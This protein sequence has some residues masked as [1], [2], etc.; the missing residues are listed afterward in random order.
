MGLVLVE[1]HSLPLAVRR[2]A[3]NACQRPTLLGI[4]EVEDI[5]PG[6]SSSGC[7]IS[8]M[9]HFRLHLRYKELHGDDGERDRKNE[10]GREKK[11]KINFIIILIISLGINLNFS[12]LRKIMLFVAMYIYLRCFWHPSTFYKKSNENKS[13]ATS[14]CT[15]NNN[16]PQA[17]R[18]YELVHCTTSHQCTAV[19]WRFRSSRSSNVCNLFRD[20][21]CHTTSRNVHLISDHLGRVEIQL[22]LTEL[23]TAKTQLNYLLFVFQYNTMLAMDSRILQLHLDSCQQTRDHWDN[24]KVLA[25][26]QHTPNIDRNMWHLQRHETLAYMGLLA[27]ASGNDTSLVCVEMSEIINWN[28]DTKVIAIMIKATHTQCLPSECEKGDEGCVMVDVIL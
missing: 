13:V 3:M 23:T 7:M 22:I 9:A 24:R 10:T 15:S 1:Y 27:L 19:R 21:K 11:S 17:N 5:L 12:T 4:F 14:I 6:S 20:R 26:H 8:L 2:N 28:L 18:S 16:R 25:G